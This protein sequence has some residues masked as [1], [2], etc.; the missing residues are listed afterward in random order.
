MSVLVAWLGNT[1]LRASE[2]ADGS[3]QGPI[4]S[5]VRAMTFGAV[6]LLSDHPAAKARAYVKWLEQQSG[7]AVTL[8]PSK[9]TS[10][11]SYEEIY[12]AAVAA[13]QAVRQSAPGAEISFHLSPGTPAMAAVWLLLA[14]TSYPARL[15]ESSREQ[16]V[17]VV[18]VPFE[19]SA[20]F[21]PAADKNADEALTR[22]MQG[23]PPE[24]PAFTSI[25]HRCSAMKRTVAM[26]HRLALREVPVLIQGES[27]SRFPIVGTSV[28]PAIGRVTILQK[29]VGALTKRIPDHLQVVGPRFAGKTVILNELAG[30]LHKLGSPYVA[31]VLWDLG[32]QTPATD[33]LFMQGFAREL[34][35]VLQGSHPDYAQHLKGDQENPYQDIAEVLDALKD[36]G[37][38]VLAIMDGFDKPLSNGQLTRNLRPDERC[39]QLWR[40]WSTPR[41][42]FDLCRNGVRS[43]AR[44]R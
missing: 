24:A 20:E 10:P 16:G 32:H 19:L 15:I 8:H 42:C 21:V 14:K 13:V 41:R 35:S 34:S 11:T 12:R 1:D 39:S 6:H 43:P 33:A 37:V 26:A 17:K 36:E 3:E 31:V 2:A 4:L 23:L 25:V 44:L 29:I 18:E 30:Q 9:L 28:P 7:V 38:K 27:G 40:F 22:L 5:A